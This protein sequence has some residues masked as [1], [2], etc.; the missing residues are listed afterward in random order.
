MEQDGTLGGP[1]V[2]G[3]DSASCWLSIMVFIQEEGT[4]PS[5]VLLSMSLNRVPMAVNA[6]IVNSTPTNT[7]R[8]ELHSMITFHH[9]NRVAQ[10]LQSSGLHICVP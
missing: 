9:A 3:R 8:T 4:T 5:S 6:F 10:E 2:R 1:S 7:A